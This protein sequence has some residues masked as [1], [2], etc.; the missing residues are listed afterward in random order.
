MFFIQVK[1]LVVANILNVPIRKYTIMMT[2]K[3]LIICVGILMVGCLYPFVTRR[4]NYLPRKILIEMFDTLASVGGV[5]F[6]S[7]VRYNP[8]HSHKLTNLKY[9]LL[10]MLTG[11]WINTSRVWQSGIGSFLADRTSGRAQGIR[12]GIVATIIEI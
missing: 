4:V 12:R 6:L 1:K 5:P 2:F 11:A 10:N 8:F 7:F 3:F 9:D